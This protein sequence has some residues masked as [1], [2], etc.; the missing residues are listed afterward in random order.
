MYDIHKS[1]TIGNSGKCFYC[2]IEGFKMTKDHFFPK[3][4]GGRLMVYSCHN[5]NGIKS[6]KTPI[7]WIHWIEQSNHSE[8]IRML[9]ASVSLGL[10]CVKN[11]VPLLGESFTL[12]SN[13]LPNTLNPIP[14]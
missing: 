12:Q 2:G 7:Q 1:K 10:K 9:T 4:M 5:C 6:S 11:G 8:K 13:Y 3:S 14:A